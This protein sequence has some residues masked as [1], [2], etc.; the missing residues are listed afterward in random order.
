[1]T[2]QLAAL[3]ALIA[4]IDAGS[5]A[6]TSRPGHRY[7][8]YDVQDAVTA[9]IGNGDLFLDVWN[10]YDDDA[11]AAFT[12]FHALLPRW[13]FELRNIGADVW[14]DIDRPFSARVTTTPTR[15]LLLASLRGFRS[16]LEDATCK[17]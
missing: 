1:M 16:T 3:D 10:A 9:A 13:K 2:A 6:P 11:N 15:A 7:A 12:V 17:P 4:D 5:W 8:E 14:R